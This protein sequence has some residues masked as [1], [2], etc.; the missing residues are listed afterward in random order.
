MQYLFSTESRPVELLSTQRSYKGHTM[1]MANDF[2]VLEN[3]DFMITD[4]SYRWHRKDYGLICL[5]NK[6]CGRCLI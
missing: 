5:E 3:G 1:K 2:E 4:S 6:G